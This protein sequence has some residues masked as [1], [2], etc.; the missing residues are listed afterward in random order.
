MFQAAYLRDLSKSNR[1]CAGIIGV[2]YGWQYLS[3]TIIVATFIPK[4]IAQY[5]RK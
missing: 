1:Y 4:S 3:K 5:E 2:L